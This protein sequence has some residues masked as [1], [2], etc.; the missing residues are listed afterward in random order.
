M[1]L[2]LMKINFILIE[3]NICHEDSKCTQNSSAVPTYRFNGLGTTQIT[4][5]TV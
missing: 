1:F 5:R 4:K 3:K 2:W